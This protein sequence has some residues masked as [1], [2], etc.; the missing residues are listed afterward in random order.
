M[1]RRT[2]FAALATITVTA[3]LAVNAGSADSVRPDV[4]AQAGADSTVPA[5]ASVDRWIPG[6]QLA[7]DVDTAVWIN[8]EGQEAL[9]P[10][11]EVDGALVLTVAAL[12]EDRVIVTARFEDLAVRPAE[13]VPDAARLSQASALAFDRSGTL[14][15]VA[16]ATGLSEAGCRLVRTFASTAQMTLSRASG[17]EAVESDTTGVYEAAY[18]WDDGELVREKMTYTQLA[19]VGGLIPADQDADT[20]AT[21]VT[22]FTL[23]ASGHPA[24]IVSTQQ[25]SVAGEELATVYAEEQAALELMDVSMVSIPD[26]PD[27]EAFGAVARPYAEPDTPSLDK[28]LVGDMTVGQL[29]GDLEALDGEEGPAAQRARIALML[30]AAAM[31]RLDPSLAASFAAHAAALGDVPS[32]HALVNALGAA[33]NADAAAALAGLFDSPDLGLTALGAAAVSAYT[34]A[35]TVDALAALAGGDSVAARSAARALGAAART[36]DMEVDALLDMAGSSDIETARA[37]IDALGNAGD[38][39]GMDQILSALDVPEL[40]ASAA[41]SLRHMPG[42]A[43]DGLLLELLLDPAVSMP[44]AQALGFRDT[45]AW[46]EPALGLI[47]G[48]HLSEATTELLLYTLEA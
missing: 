2:A 25:M 48:G 19:T 9:A 6:L 18:A 44:A 35:A 12:V 34:D 8:V 36:G 24:R 42:E 17:W 41:Y 33:A 40:A 21:G 46:A 15:E 23:H 45:S 32:A 27:I 3:A 38:P 14:R 22:S 11:L 39:R 4:R 20:T 13:M 43:V 47:D 7:Y 16:C 28:S 31:L 29:L 10:T 30:R 5:R 37:G 1:N 26:V